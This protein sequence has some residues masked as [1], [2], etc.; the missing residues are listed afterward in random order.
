MIEQINDLIPE[1]TL[2][3]KPKVDEQ[4][5]SDTVNTAS[6]NIASNVESESNGAD[7][8]NNVNEQVQNV[9]KTMEDAEETSEGVA[10][11]ADA[12]AS[13]TRGATKAQKAL[14][15][16]MSGMNPEF[17]KWVSQ[18]PN[19]TMAQYAGKLIKTEAA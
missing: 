15:V 16:A 13:R 19:A 6:D 11:A 2:E 4:Q 12:I 8:A 14:V 17:A 7:I 5:V 3:F 18:N 1:F 9:V 10:E